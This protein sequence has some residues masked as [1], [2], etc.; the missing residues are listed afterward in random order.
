MKHLQ[1]EFPLEAV[2]AVLRDF[3]DYYVLGH[4]EEVG[5]AWNEYV[6]KNGRNPLAGLRDITV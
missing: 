1:G 6:R 4:P 5:D 3:W 2:L